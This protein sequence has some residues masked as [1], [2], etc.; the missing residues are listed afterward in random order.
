M[1]LPEPGEYDLP[2]Y[3]DWTVYVTTRGEVRHRC[4]HI[5][6]VDVA[7]NYG[8][9]SN[10]TRY[11]DELCAA[12]SRVVRSTLKRRPERIDR[13]PMRLSFAEVALV[14]FW[15]EV[16]GGALAFEALQVVDQTA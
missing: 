11:R 3:A 1:T 10:F 9:C 14:K 12:H 7:G 15:F 13:P 5:R 16:M 6:W 2:V 8:Q 4:Q